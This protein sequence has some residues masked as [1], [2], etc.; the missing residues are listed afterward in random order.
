MLKKNKIIVLVIGLGSIGLR[1]VNILNKIKK[2]QTILVY[3]SRKKK[4]YGKVVFIKNLKSANCADYI[5]IS[6]KTSDHYKYL[7]FSENYFKNKIILVEKPLFEK[8]KV[9]KIKNNKVFVGYNLRFHPILN[10]I[11]KIIKNR[12]I[13]SV[14]LSCL[15]YLPEWRKNIHHKLSYSSIKKNGGGVLLDLSHELDYLQWI[16]GNIS[17]INFSNIDKISNITKDSEDYA[18]LIGKINNINFILNL[19]YFSQN[20]KREIIIDGKDFSLTAD[21]IKNKVILASD[22]KRK[23]INFKVDSDYT[24]EQQHLS[25]IRNN[26]RNLCNWIE[27]KKYIDLIDKIKKQ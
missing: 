13:F 25:I 4:K 10:F 1:H 14:Y 6:S 18:N 24:Y 15:S 9:I 2:V 22:N 23:N 8:S 3:S 21:L 19:N 7:K 26:H 17:Q 27:A 12:K 16:F 5:I 20:V 11:K